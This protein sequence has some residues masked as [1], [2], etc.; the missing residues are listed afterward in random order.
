MPYNG[1]A[2]TYVYTSMGELPGFVIGWN[3]TLRY[4]IC[5]GVLA[6]AWAE[7]LFGLFSLIGMDL[8]NWINHLDIGFT[9]GSPLAVMFIIGSYIIIA[10]GTKTSIFF[11][12]ILTAFKVVLIVSIIF[13]GLPYVNS[14]NWNPFFSNGVFGLVK[15]SS[16]LFFGYLGFDCVTTVSEE[17]KN[18]KRDIPR[19]VLYC[20]F[21]CGAIYIAFSLVVLGVANLEGMN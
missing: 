15:A 16:I 8:P 9:V 13:L 6:R 18:P 20:T 2:Y 7:Y 21:I 11:T 5:A 3:Q 14:S 1:S 10:Q 19:A 12:T 4:G 17:A